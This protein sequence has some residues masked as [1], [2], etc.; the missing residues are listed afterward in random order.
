MRTLRDLDCVAS[1]SSFGMDVEELVEEG[2]LEQSAWALV[3]RARQFREWE[4]RAWDRAMARHL[5]IHV[6]VIQM[7][8]I[9]L[10]WEVP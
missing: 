7:K 9:T 1:T 2:N 6:R 5:W 3:R 4:R 10:G 8:S